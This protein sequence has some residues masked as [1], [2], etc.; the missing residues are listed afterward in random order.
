MPQGKLLY[1]TTQEEFMK[2]KTQFKKLT[3]FF[4]ILCLIIS[5]CVSFS[6]C[7]SGV[8]IGGTSDPASPEELLL[9]ISQEPTKEFDTVA[10]YLDF[11][12]FPEFSKSKLSTLESLYR[13]QFV[14]EL[15]A[16]YEKAKAVGEY[17]IEYFYTG[18]EKSVTETT[19]LLIHS[20]VETSGDAYSIYRTAA[21]YQEYDAGMSGSF[22]GIGVTVRY[23]VETNEI[24]VESVTDGGGAKEAGIL[25]GDYIIKVNG[26]SID[27]LGYEKAISNIRGEPN[28]TVDISVLR[29]NEEKTFTITRRQIVEKS[30]TYEIKDSVAFVKITGFKGNTAAQFKTAVD[31]ALACGIKGIIYDLRDNSGGYLDTVLEMLDYIAPSG[32]ILASF[33]NN[34][35]E[36]KYSKSNHT[37]NLPTVVLCNGYTASAGELFTAG[38]RDFSDMGFFPATLV[39]EKTFGKGIMQNTYLFNDHSSITMTV[40]YYNPPSGVNYHDVGITPDVTVANGEGDPQLTTAYSEI[41]KLINK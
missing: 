24:L 14:E 29:G 21:E 35:M 19:D 12:Q 5:S 22:V 36:P 32:T 23:S 34:Y 20:F 27:T 9:T 13:R 3:L 1:L 26:E 6:S 15:P 16:P 28:T 37:V 30:V 2:I 41:A 33:T 39:G 4:L 25:P 31:E 17:F 38:I 10:D 7:I 8:G 40:A 11:W 18:E